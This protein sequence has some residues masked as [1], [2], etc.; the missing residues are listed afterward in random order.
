M[1]GPS[2]SDSCPF[3]CRRYCTARL[4][5]P[6]SVVQLFVASRE[7]KLADSS[8]P[9]SSYPSYIDC[10][11]PKACMKCTH[12]RSSQRWTLSRTRPI[13]HLWQTIGKVYA[14]PLGYETFQTLMKL[15]E[16]TLKLS[17]SDG[18]DAVSGWRDR[19][20]PLSFKGR[21]IKSVLS[22]F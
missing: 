16:A 18:G 19:T 20:P 17:D 21:R 11:Q 15:N 9:E 2:D 8:A 12:G 13:S 10:N 5:Y 14:H 7:R 1:R 6:R 3:D 4:G 22:Q